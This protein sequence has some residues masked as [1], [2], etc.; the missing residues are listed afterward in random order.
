MV[1]ADERQLGWRDVVPKNRTRTFN[2][3]SGDCLPR[4]GWG[5]RADAPR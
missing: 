2:S 1:M 4:M 3:G 5:G